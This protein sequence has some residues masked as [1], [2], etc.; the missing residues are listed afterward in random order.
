M[1]NLFITILA[2]FAFSATA[3]PGNT[4]GGQISGQ[5]LVPISTE[6]PF[7]LDRSFISSLWVDLYG[8]PFIPDESAIWLGEHIDDDSS[9]PRRAVLFENDG[10]TVE[11]P[12][13]TE[14]LVFE[15][16]NRFPVNWV[17]LVNGHFW[18]TLDDPWTGLPYP[19]M[20]MTTIQYDD[21]LVLRFQLPDGNTRLIV[22]FSE[23][24]EINIVNPTSE[25][26]SFVME[27][28]WP[29]KRF[30]SESQAAIFAQ[31]YATHTP[32]TGSVDFD[33]LQTQSDPCAG[34]TG[35]IAALCYCESDIITD[36]VRDMGN[37]DFPAGGL[38]TA[39]AGGAA[40][41]AVGAYGGGLIKNVIKKLTG[42][43]QGAIVAATTVVGASAGYG[44]QVRA[45]K[46]RANS[47]YDARRRK[48]LNSYNQA[49][50]TGAP[51]VCPPAGGLRLTE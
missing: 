49:N 7:V 42:F 17:D 36:F 46:A 13:P 44:L 12:L 45:C 25:Q 30:F 39:L 26:S 2:I 32:P 22:G 19:P 5:P 35:T 15:E 48:A 51:F 33:F 8:R 20:E 21:A 23:V 47:D 43:G 27:V 41:A 34:L 24:L 31:D 50:N 3:Q 9:K 28:F 18:T 1:K 38:E 37:C 40:G 29:I 10:T 16:L 11:A 4:N 14:H 6:T